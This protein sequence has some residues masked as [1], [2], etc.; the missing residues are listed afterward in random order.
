MT[1]QEIVFNQTNSISRRTYLVVFISIT[2]F[3]F[4]FLGISQTLWS[5]FHFTDDHEIIEFHHQVASLQTTL[6][7]AIVQQIQHDIWDFGRFRPFYYVYRLVQIEIFGTHWLILSIYNGFL[8]VFTTFLFFTFGIFSQLSIVESLV[9]T[10]ITVLGG[11]SA[12]WWQLA[13][14]E[15]IATLLLILSLNLLILSIKKNQIIFKVFYWVLFVLTTLCKESFLLLIPAILLLEFS[16]YLKFHQLSVR[17]TIIKTLPSLFLLTFVGLA[18]IIFIKFFIDTDFGY[19]GLIFDLPSLLK[20][21]KS[22]GYVS[23]IAILYGLLI[24]SRVNQPKEENSYIFITIT[25]VSILFCLIVFPQ[26]ILYSKSGL[27]NHYFLPGIIGYALLITTLLHTIRIRSQLLGYLVLALIGF[28]LFFRLNSAF[29]TAQSFAQEG[30]ATNTLL[31]WVTSRTQPNHEIVIISNPYRHFEWTLSIAKYLR[32]TAQANNLYLSTY[33]SQKSDYFTSIFIPEGEEQWFYL[34]L[35]VFQQYYQPF[36]AIQ[37][38][39]KV[40]CV[41]VFPKLRDAFLANSSTWFSQNNYEEYVS[42]N[43]AI[44]AAPFHIYTLKSSTE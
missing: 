15:T 42:E 35:S 5:G 30:K 41:I 21:W 19:A 33:G 8:A 4:L 18:E 14:A 36:T 16:F 11:Q 23:S 2:V 40:K 10:I 29:I 38:Q 34:D 12:V 27:R 43:F 31:D 44:Y 37:N 25:I 3:W 39:Q 7:G 6:L 24:L 13:P 17:R 9:F 26:A 1:V 20:T 28:A 22:Y 32:Y